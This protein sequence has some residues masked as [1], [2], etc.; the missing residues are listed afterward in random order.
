M[1]DRT[2]TANG[3]Q[4]IRSLVCLRKKPKDRR[5]HLARQTGPI[6]LSHNAA[7]A[8]EV[9]DRATAP[10]PNPGRGNGHAHQ[11]FA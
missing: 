9:I 7:L 11:L 10:P 4:T 3:S 1:L 6:I 5:V 8:L 2:S